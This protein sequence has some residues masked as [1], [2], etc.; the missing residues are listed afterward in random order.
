MM[1]RCSVYLSTQPDEAFG[2]AIVE[3]MSLG[4]IPLV[5]RG[6]G[7]WS[8][9]LLE[10]EEYGLAYSTSDEA[11]EKIRMILNDETW[12]RELREEGI[13]HAHDFTDDVFRQ[14]FTDFMNRLEPREKQDHRLYKWY[15][16]INSLKEKVKQRTSIL[17]PL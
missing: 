14:R 1:N 11:V 15:R 10:N 8:D 6:G 3:A 7:P 17:A 4:C 5:Y 2:M 16:K 13:I 9:I 12:R